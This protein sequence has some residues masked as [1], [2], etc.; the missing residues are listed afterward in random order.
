MVFP[1]KRRFFIFSVGS[2][3]DI[4]DTVEDLAA[5]KSSAY[6]CFS[7]AERTT[8]P[9]AR[10]GGL[11]HRRTDWGDVLLLKYILE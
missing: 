7:G 5:S 10:G 3:R 2:E 11:F 9:G 6:R 1:K 8:D 4:L